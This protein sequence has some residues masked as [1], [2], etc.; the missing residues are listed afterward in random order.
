[1][2]SRKMTWDELLEEWTKCRRELTTTK[3]ELT[4]LKAELNEL[5]EER[6]SYDDTYL[7]LKAEHTKIGLAFAKEIEEHQELKQLVRELIIANDIYW[8]VE[9]KMPSYLRD[10][11]NKLKQKVEGVR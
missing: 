8:N 1:M 3:G 9:D 10:Y 5:R 7:T 4:E 2:D 6:K 11:H